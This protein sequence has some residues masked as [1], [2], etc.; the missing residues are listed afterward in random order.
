VDVIRAI[1]PKEPIIRNGLDWGF[2][3]VRAGPNPV[4]RTGIVHGAHPY[5][6]K[7]LPC[8][9]SF[10]HLKARYPVPAS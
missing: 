10:G 1:D 5:P 3:L 7:S 4:R 2:N 6:I 8:D 9:S